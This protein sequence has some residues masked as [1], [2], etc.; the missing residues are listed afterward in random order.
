CLT[1]NIGCPRTASGSLSSVLEDEVSRKYFLSKAMIE[2]I[3]KKM[4]HK[5]PLSNVEK[6]LKSPIRG[7]GDKPIIL[8]NIYG[9]FKEKEPRVFIEASPTIRTPK[10]GGYLPGVFKGN[11]I[12]R[13]TPRECERLQGFPDDWT[14]GVSDTQRY[15][16]MGNAVSVPVVEAI[17]RK[18]LEFVNQEVI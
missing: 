5:V 12:R 1:L 3:K 7:Q 6:E 15:K 16:A 9:G 18:I 17:G 11:C 13:L 4:H 14:K 10:G 2:Y 8:H